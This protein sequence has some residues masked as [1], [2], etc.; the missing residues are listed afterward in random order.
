[1]NVKYL[2]IGSL[3]LMVSG[4][5]DVGGESINVAKQVVSQQY[6]DTAAVTFKKANY[7]PKRD[8]EGIVCGEFSNNGGTSRFIV[9]TVSQNES[10]KA[11]TPFIENAG[12][13]TETIN[14]LWNS[15]CK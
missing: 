1:M 11:T 10:I 8:G 2:M 14:L 3:L 6:P 15:E 5:G 12:T 9:A 4:C 7:Y 13:P